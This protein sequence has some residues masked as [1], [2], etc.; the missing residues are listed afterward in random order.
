MKK[1][2]QRILVL[3]LALVMLLSVLVPVLSALADASVTQNDINNIK[4]ELSDITAEKN[5]VQKQLNAIRGDKS[6][7]KQ[8][9]ELLQN[10][11]LLTE[12]EIT[13]CQRL[14][15]RYDLDIQSREEELSSLEAEEKQRYAEFC[16]HVRWMEE[17]GSISYLS[18]LFEAGS[19]AELLDRTT[20]IS[21]VME[22]SNRI[23]DNLKAVQQD[24]TAVKAELQVARDEQQAVQEDLLNQQAEL[25]DQRAEANKLYDQIAENEAELAAQAKALAAEETKIQQQLKKA[26]QQYA[27]QLAA[28]QNSGQWYWPLP[29][30]NLLSSLFGARKDPFTGKASNHT[31]VDVPALSGEKICAAQG[32]VVTYV[33]T[34]RYASSYGY[35]VIV[36]HGNGKSTLYAH[37][38]TAAIVKAGQTVK[39]GQV[40]GYVGTTGRSTG[41]H[42]H[43]EYRINGTRADALTLYPGMTFRTYSGATIKGG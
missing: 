23:I 42:L 36:S 28:L 18:I 19:F 24:V 39:K 43:F 21:D 33:E 20:L 9:I 1:K 5:A 16:A 38:K 26:E 7:A 41:N 15:D 22:Y 4:G 11:I 40:I 34:N 10:Q 27:A 14:L 29:G 17:T 32:G 3:V 8:Q 30:R 31:G 12:H 37:M 2:T 25:E 35:Y 13:T 6:K